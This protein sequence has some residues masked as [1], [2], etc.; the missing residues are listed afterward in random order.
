MFL[1][2]KGNVGWFGMTKDNY[3]EQPKKSLESPPP[4]IT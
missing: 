4:P 1:L 2:K 3:Y